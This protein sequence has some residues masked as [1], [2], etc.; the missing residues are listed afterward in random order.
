MARRRRAGYARGLSTGRPQ[1]RPPIEGSCSRPR[2]ATRYLDSTASCQYDSILSM[3]LH[4]TRRPLRHPRR[5]G[6]RPPPRRAAHRP[7]HRHA[8]RRSSPSRSRPSPSP[9]W[10]ACAMLPDVALADARPGRQRAARAARAPSCGTR[11]AATRSP[12]P[13]PALPRRRR[14]RSPRSAAPRRASRAPACSTRA[15]TPAPRRIPRR[16]GL[17]GRRA[18][19]RRARRRRRRPH[20][21][22]PAV[23]GPVRARDARRLG[24]A[25]AEHAGR[26]RGRVR[27]RRRRPPT[28]RSCR[29]PRERAGGGAAAR[30][31][32]RR[33]PEPAPQ[34][35]AGAALTD[36]DHRDVPPQRA[37][38]GGRAGARG[39]GRA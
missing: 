25:S 39:R 2:S 31:A 30:A 19:R 8:V 29:R 3:T 21:R 38:A 7:L 28:R 11:A 16:H 17:R 34:S 37:A 18:L 36:A 26:V 24:L 13:R 15:A 14:A 35:E 1:R 23:P 33:W 27:P 10:A 20:H 4:R 9:R 5:L 32:A 6:G 12:R 22:R